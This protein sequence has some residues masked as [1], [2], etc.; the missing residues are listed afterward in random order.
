M[1]QTPL[2]ELTALPRPLAG[3]GGGASRQGRGWAAEEEGK[4]EGREGKWSR[5][6]GRAPKLLLNQGP[7]DSKPCYATVDIKAAWVVSFYLTVRLL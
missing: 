2:G 1:P 6:K 7:S 4:G 5:G 3:L